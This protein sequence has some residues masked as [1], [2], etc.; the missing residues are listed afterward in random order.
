[1]CYVLCVSCFV[2]KDSKKTGT[3]YLLSIIKSFVMGIISQKTL[4]KNYVLTERELG[5]IISHQCS[6][7]PRRKAALY[8]LGE[9]KV[10]SA[11]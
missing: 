9:E 2:V 8:P 1:M 7:K 6:G 5:T 4:P 10:I 11:I 3:I